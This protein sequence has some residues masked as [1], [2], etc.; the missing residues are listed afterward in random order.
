M[1]IKINRELEIV[2]YWLTNDDQNDE[3]LIA[4]LKEQ[5]PQWRRQNLMPVVYR[6]GHEDL[7]ETTLALLKYNRRRS[8]ER[9]LAEEQEGNKTLLM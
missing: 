9:D 2:E 1:E 7:F 6:S 5:Y 8:A 3:K 4:W